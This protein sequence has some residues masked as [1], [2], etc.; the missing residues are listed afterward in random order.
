MEIQLVG[1]ENIKN[2][3]FMFSKCHSLLSIDIS[4][5]KTFNIENM[6]YMFNSC[7]LQTLPDEIANINTEKVKYMN[8]MFSNCKSL[9]SLPDISKW[10]TSNVQNMKHIIHI[11]NIRSIPF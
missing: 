10:N 3:S 2:I 9:I 1:I 8:C 5:W 4:N 7:H 6:S 11:S